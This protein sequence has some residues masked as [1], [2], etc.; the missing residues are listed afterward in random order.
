[1]RRRELIEVHTPP[2][3]SFLKRYNK[4]AERRSEKSKNLDDN[5]YPRNKDINK[6][7]YTDYDMDIKE[8]NQLKFYNEIASRNVHGKMDFPTLKEIERITKDESC[9]DLFKQKEKEKSKD[10]PKILDDLPLKRVERIT[11]KSKE[12]GNLRRALGV[13]CLKNPFVYIN[14]EKG[15]NF[16]R[17][18]FEKRMRRRDRSENTVTI[19]DLYGTQ[20]SP[21]KNR[22]VVHRTLNDSWIRRH[23]LNNNEDSVKRNL[24]N[25][26]KNNSQ[27]TNNTNI[28]NTQTNTNWSSNSNNHKIYLNTGISLNSSMY[29][30]RNNKV[31]N[32]QRKR[33]ILNLFENP[34]KENESKNMNDSEIKRIKYKRKIDKLEKDINKVSINSNY[35]NNKKSLNY[36]IINPKNKENIQ[37]N[38]NQS[39]YLRYKKNAN[40]SFKQ[41]NKDIKYENESKNDSF[42]FRHRNIR[43]NYD[44]KNDKTVMPDKDINNKNKVRKRFGGQSQLELNIK[45]YEK[46]DEKNNVTINYFNVTIKKKL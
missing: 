8:K 7:G 39:M 3:K 18:I 19:D 45:K 14:R 41:R 28:Q 36:Q 38:Q 6:N 43:S 12:I 29:E 11:Y 10:L 24:D 13:Y 15:E 44:L 20:I 35:V 21:R 33:R 4:N 9:L 37:D 22:S 17:N 27:I 16:A 2:D 26:M 1:M 30:I 31:S 32:S 25:H 34:G 23:R 46:K 42:C 5:L 40:N